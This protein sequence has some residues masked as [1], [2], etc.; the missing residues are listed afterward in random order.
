LIA[1]L[2]PRL[3]SSLAIARQELLAS[4][5]ASGHWV[6]ELSPSALSTATAV[7]AL[8]IVQ[9]ESKCQSAG[10]KATGTAAPA[11]P[12]EVIDRGL[13]WLANNINGDGGWGDTPTSLSN[14]STT[15]LCWGAFG[16][17]P[18]ADV[19]HIDVVRRIE[20]WFTWNLKFFNVPRIVNAIVA[21]YG[22]DRTFSA[23]ILTMLAL[24]GRI[25]QGAEAW[26]RVIP[27]PFELAAFPHSWF[28]ALKLPVV[29]Y[30]LPAL[31]AI[32]QARHHHLPPRNRLVR[33][34]RDAARERTLAKL[35]QLQ[36]DNGGFLEAT[37]LTSFV[38]MS[39]AGSGQVDHPVVRKGVEFLLQSQRCDGSWP[40]DTNLATWLTTLAV[41]AL[42]G[43]R[44][45]LD[46]QGLTALDQSAIRSWLLRQ[47][48]RVVH[49]YTQAAPG[50]WAW[51]DLPGGVPDADD[52]AGAL[53]ALKHLSHAASSDEARSGS[54]AREPEIH[55]AAVLGVRW[56]LDLQNRDGGIPT[57]CRGWGNL[58]FD[59][60]APDLTAHALQAWALW[61]E[62]LPEPLRAR[63]RKAIGKAVYFLAYE[64]RKDGAWV[65]LWFGNEMSPTE[66][67]PT[68]GTSRVLVAL[69]TLAD[70]KLAPVVRLQAKALNWL[71]KAQRA[72]G[73]WGGDL[74][75]HSSTEETALAVE[76]LAA[77]LG[78]PQLEKLLPHERLEAALYNAAFWL[79]EQ[80]ETG[81]WMGPAPIGFYFAKLWYFERLYPQIFTVAALE[82]TVKA[83]K[84]G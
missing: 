74:E 54:G 34:L 23:P 42:A 65:P 13:D 37:P 52:T 46:A 20:D 14:V 61:L 57:F 63:V 36:P 72:D 79:C 35:T 30:A 41:N 31:I 5:A 51:T 16:A 44:E 47:Q 83:V 12:P 9:R 62:D 50:G 68:Y 17:V 6:G 11:I 28:A 70:R 40:I 38:V 32:G 81:C 60:S 55:D 22:K 80:I 15:A 76:A 45:S 2:L 29:S 78:S 19:E 1:D 43:G 26:E 58:P 84:G 4:R 67:N 59:R 25:G 53:V 49:P 71:L 7:A 39:L 69:R 64:Q 27:L 75:S 21:R 10:P 56:L 82:R 66:E 73:S 18:G 48:Y 24:T 8:A 77:S 33:R 3:E